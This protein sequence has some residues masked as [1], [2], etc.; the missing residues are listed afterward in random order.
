M[1]QRQ[2]FIQDLEDKLTQYN[3]VRACCA[4][5]CSTPA[6]DGWT[7][8]FA[9]ALPLLGGC[10]QWFDSLR[11]GLG[12]KAILF[13]T[14]L[15]VSP[16][17]YCGAVHGHPMDIHH[18]YE[19]YLGYHGIR[20]KSF[21]DRTLR[22]LRIPQYWLGGHGVRFSTPIGKSTGGE[23]RAPQHF[24]L[25][26]V[27][28]GQIA[29]IKMTQELR[30]HHLCAWEGGG[31]LLLIDKTPQDCGFATSIQFKLERAPA[32]PPGH[33][34]RVHQHCDVC[35]PFSSSHPENERWDR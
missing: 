22:W 9:C 7:T 21:S 15:L 23:E 26:A 3:S 14:S 1:R 29:D 4:A 5:S 18:F 13:Y 10:Y 19:F 11:R 33:E 8:P 32:H 35:T 31:K 6:A 16:V 34:L 20:T 24:V 30:P 25:E 28:S 27:V 17:A 12:F 2:L